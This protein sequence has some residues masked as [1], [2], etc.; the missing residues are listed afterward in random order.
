MP[1]LKTEPPALEDLSKIIELPL[2]APELTDEQVS[3]GCSL[4]R[5]YGLAAVILRPS[6]LDSAERWIGSGVAL[7]AVIDWPHG[8]STTAVK[9]YAVRDALRRGA[10]EITV[11]MNTSKLVSR[12]FQYLEMELQQLVDACHEAHA[13]LTVNLESQHLNEEQKIVACRVAKRTR[14]DFL[15][16]SDL[17]DIA[18]LAQYAQDR[19]QLKL[20]AAMTLEAAL[21]AHAAGCKRIETPNA[22][23]ILDAWKNHLAGGA[24]DRLVSSGNTQATKDDGRRH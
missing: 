24:D 4:A 17:R 10:K 3:A 23:E 19:V 14:A 15:A 12:Q 18:F 6:D 9:Q 16:T 13:L 8:Y 21:E 20:R 7:G 22:A 11:T 2:L 1:E 5:R